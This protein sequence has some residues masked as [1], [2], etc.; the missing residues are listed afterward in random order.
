MYSS[1]PVIEIDHYKSPKSE[2]IPGRKASIWLLKQHISFCL[3][4]NSLVLFGHLLCA[5]C[6]Q[7]IS[8]KHDFKAVLIAELFFNT[9]YTLSLELWPFC[10]CWVIHDISNCLRAGLLVIPDSVLM[11]ASLEWNLTISRIFHL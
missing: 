2:H 10:L 8:K 3:D 7:T 1:L 6:Q 9:F 11:K 4:N 5:E